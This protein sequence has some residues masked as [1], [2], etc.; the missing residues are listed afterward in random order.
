MRVLVTGGAGYIGSITTRW[1]LDAG[2]T[3]VVLDSLVRGHRE[4]VDDRARFVEADV[5]DAPAVRDAADGC[6]AVLHC[7][8]YIEVAESQA[9]PALYVENN[10][11]R[12]VAMMDA[13]VEAGVGTIVFSSTAATYGEP[14]SIPIA[15]DARTNPVNVY[16]ATKLAFERV[17]DWYGT[18]HG[19]R[20]VRLRYF[21]VAGAWPDG[22]L[23]EAHEPETHIVP[24]ILGSIARGTRTFEV[25]GNDYPTRDGTCVRDY[26]HV[27]DLADAHRRALEHAVSGGTG[28]F[29][30]GNGQGF[31]NLEVVR[32]CGEA[33]G[34]EVDI[35]FGPRRS[36]D[37]ATLVASAT[38]ARDALEWCPAHPGIETIVADAWRW[39]EA[40]PSGYHSLAKM[41]E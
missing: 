14:E 11:R 34:E 29:N 26:I 21:N 40:H 41:V 27:C 3:V 4:A 39:H 22:S 23:G 16:G 19:V 38:R 13:L 10:L 15:E 33:C 5:S 7:A 12:P 8:G 25:Y 9:D 30:L 18:A 37:P 17:L 20:S 6:D 2:F 24:R 1:L 28:V 36:G 31:T 32:A 35:T